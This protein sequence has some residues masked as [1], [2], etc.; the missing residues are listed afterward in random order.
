MMSPA[1]V[2]FRITFTACKPARLPKGRLLACGK[3]PAKPIPKMTKS[4]RSRMKKALITTVMLIGLGTGFTLAPAS[5]VYAEQTSTGTEAGQQ[6]W[7]DALNTRIDLVQAKTSLLHARIAL[8]IDQSPRAGAAGFGGCANL[9]VK[10]KKERRVRCQGTD[11]GAV[12]RHHNGPR[13]NCRNAGRG[14]R[15]DRGI[16]RNDRGVAAGL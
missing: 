9:G 8:E 10:S 3:G 14:P 7:L 12:G 4:R 15:K 6:N 2:N 13:R 16:D 11:A 5:S 1:P